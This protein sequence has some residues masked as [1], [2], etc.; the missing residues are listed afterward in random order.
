MMRLTYLENGCFR[1]RNSIIIIHTA[2]SCFPVTKKS[3]IMLSCKNILFTNAIK[4][5]L[6]NVL[7]CH[8]KCRDEIRARLLAHLLLSPLQNPFYG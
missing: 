1:F 5:S 8:L 4:A 7:Q 6:T 3:V 2:I